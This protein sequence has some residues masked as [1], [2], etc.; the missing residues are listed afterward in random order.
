MGFVRLRP[1]DAGGI[2]WS[3][4]LESRASNSRDSLSDKAF[5]STSEP[6]DLASSERGP[7]Q[8][9]G[10]VLSRLLPSLPL[11]LQPGALR[12]LAASSASF[13][14]RGWDRWPPAARI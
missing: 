6:I 10:Q 8:C 4:A 3:P 1:R 9:S 5:D 12:H 14:G 7:L 2:S 11:D 13:R